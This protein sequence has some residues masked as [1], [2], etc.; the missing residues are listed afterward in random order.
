MEACRVLDTLLEL[1]PWSE[2]IPWDRMV[3]DKVEGTFEELASLE[4][5]A[6]IQLGKMEA[7]RVVDTLKAL[8]PWSLDIQLGKKELDKVVDTSELAVVASSFEERN[9]IL[10]SVDIQLDKQV[11]G[12]VVDT[13]RVLPL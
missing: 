13:W 7:C 8:Q 12:K 9:R 6:C 1:K 4:Q 2:G 11:L 10:G 3:L 5:L